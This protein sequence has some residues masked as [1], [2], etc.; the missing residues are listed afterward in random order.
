MSQ[1]EEKWVEFPERISQSVDD[2]R[3]AKYLRKLAALF[4]HGHP[5][6]SAMRIFWRHPKAWRYQVQIVRVFI[7]NALMRGYWRRIR[8]RRKTGIMPPFL[9]AI[10]PTNRCN[11]ACEG[12]YASG[13][14]P[15]AELT[16]AEVEDV[17]R[18]ARR[19]G[20]YFVVI[21][22][23]EPF[24]WPGLMELVEQ[25]SDMMFLIYTNGTYITSDI[26]SRLARTANVAPALSLEGGERETDERRGRGVYRRIEEAFRVLREARAMVRVWLAVSLRARGREHGP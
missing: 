21:T 3:Y 9:F 16:W 23:G 4:R 18:Q 12:C 10:S 26:A 17:I 22:G 20:I 6:A 13:N 8:Y 14:S 15:M 7:L 11:L 25:Y 2:P 1:S 24:M 19:L 5:A